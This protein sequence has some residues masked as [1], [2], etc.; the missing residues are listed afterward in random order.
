LENKAGKIV[1]ADD[2]SVAKTLEAVALP[3]DLRALDLN[4]TAQ[5]IFNAGI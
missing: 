3:A 5:Q 4:L 2:Q 1:V